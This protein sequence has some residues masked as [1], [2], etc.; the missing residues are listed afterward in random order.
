MFDTLKRMFASDPAELHPEIDPHVAATALLVEAALADGIY[1]DCEQDR[2]RH[3]LENAFK[4]APPRA[5]SVLEHAE[6]LAE[7]A[8]DDLAFEIEMNVVGL[9][10]MAQAFA[11]VL[12]ANGGGAFVQLNSVASLK[13][14][15]EFATYSASK[16]A[17]YSI[18]QALREVLAQQG[19]AVVSVHPGPINTDM[20]HNAGLGEI[21]EPPSLVG[22]GIVAALKA[23]DFHHFP[24]TMAK[25]FGQAYEAFAV[26]IV[27]AEISEN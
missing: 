27:E 7:T 13:N 6:E 19:T 15:A 16:A 24:D 21:A 23:A 2:I 5:S 11:P 3:I 22:D 9:L 10:R 8:I 1:A 20:A 25:Q 12:K 14:F 4:L 17:S 18:T 26:S